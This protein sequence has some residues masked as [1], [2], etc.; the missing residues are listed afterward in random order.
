MGP[1]MSVKKL[2]IFLNC[3]DLHKGNGKA[4]AAVKTAKTIL[5]KSEDRQAALLLYRN[6]PPKGYNYSP[7]QR[8]LSRRTRTMLP[9]SDHLLQPT[10]IN[11]DQVQQDITI[12]RRTSKQNYDRTAGPPHTPLPLGSYVYA[13]PPLHRRGKPWIYGSITAR[14]KPRSYTISTPT[15]T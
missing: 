5:R 2:K 6:T 7:V 8:M 3:M 4:K 12:R 9:T 10:I 11:Y 15:G 14:D 13:K 1:N